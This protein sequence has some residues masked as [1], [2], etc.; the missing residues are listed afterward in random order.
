MTIT[1]K[2]VV[3]ETGTP[4]EA[5]IPWDQFVELQE[6]LGLDFTI[7]EAEELSAARRDLAEGNW[8]A[9]V[10]SEEVRRDLGR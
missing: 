3:D 2:R 4:R 1:H 9:F 6:V 8:D 10:D 5:I 7:G